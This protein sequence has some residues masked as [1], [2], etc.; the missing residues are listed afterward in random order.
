[1]KWAKKIQ[2]EKYSEVVII[3][4]HPDDE[5]MFFTPIILSL[6]QTCHLSLIC[7]SNGNAEGLGKI[8]EQELYHACSILGIQSNDIYLVNNMKLLDGMTTHWPIDIVSDIVMEYLVKISPD[9]VALHSFR[10][11]S[12]GD[13]L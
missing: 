9:L 5:S 3:V 2:F 4:A 13:N 7:L 1:M 11:I 10:F 6:I 12:L 8:R